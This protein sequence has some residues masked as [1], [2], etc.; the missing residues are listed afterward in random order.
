MINSNSNSS[1]PCPNIGDKTDN[2]I[3]DVYATQPNIAMKDLNN[4]SFMNSSNANYNIT[5]HNIDYPNVM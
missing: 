2:V 3:N 1:S 5:K 4:Q